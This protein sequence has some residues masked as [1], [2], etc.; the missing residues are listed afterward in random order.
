LPFTISELD[1]AFKGS[2]ELDIAYVFARFLLHIHTA[3][4]FI[5]SSCCCKSN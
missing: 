3:F 1:V 4:S 2:A 5:T